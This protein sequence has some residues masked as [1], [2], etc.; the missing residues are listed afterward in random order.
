M[1]VALNLYV[2]RQQKDAAGDFFRAAQKQRPGQYQGLYLVA[3]DG[4]VLAS[5][6]N[7]KSH[8]TWAEELLADLR[9]GLQAFGKVKPREV[10]RS[11]PTP[12]RGCGAQPGRPP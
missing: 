8:K 7:F 12:Q 1:P 11:D 2:I 4:K 5:H 10:R 6:Q 3:P 9:P